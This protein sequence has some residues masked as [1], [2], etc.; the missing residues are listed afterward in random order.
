[1][2]RQARDRVPELSCGFPKQTEEGP[3]LYQLPAPHKP[4]QKDSVVLLFQTEAS[5]ISLRYL[6]NLYVRAVNGVFL[7]S[8]LKII[9]GLSL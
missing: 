8:P 2:D 5:V 1:M 4:G 3:V 7:T 9:H 6:C